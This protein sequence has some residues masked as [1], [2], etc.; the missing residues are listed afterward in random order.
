MLVRVL[1]TSSSALTLGSS[2]GT[3]DPGASLV[4]DLTVAQLE[5]V[6]TTLN[7]LKLKGFV[8]WQVTP[9]THGEEGQ[10]E[11]HPAQALATK[12]QG[13]LTLWVNA[14]TGADRNAGT[15]SQP[16]ASLVEAEKRIPDI[17][18]HPVTIHVGPHRGNGYQPPEFRQRVYHYSID[19][20]ADSGGTLGNGCNLLLSGV[21]QSGSSHVAVISEA[22]LGVDTYRG[23]TIEMLEGPSANWRRTIQYH[24]DENIVPA[25]LWEGGGIAQGQ[26]FRVIEPAVRL[27]M[28]QLVPQKTWRITAGESVY[29]AIYG[30]EGRYLEYPGVNLVNFVIAGGSFNINAGHHV[31]LFGCE[32][33]ADAPS[34]ALFQGPI[35]AGVD[36]IF[37][38]TTDNPTQPYVEYSNISR[39]LGGGRQDW[40][41]WGLNAQRKVFID[42]SSYMY[43]YGLVAPQLHIYGA[44]TNVHFRGGNIFEKGVTVR[45]GAIFEANAKVY[46]PD[47]TCH[48]THLTGDAITVRDFGSQVRLTAT[49]LRAENGSGVYLGEGAQALFHVEVGV[50]ADVGIELKHGAKAHLREVTPNFTTTTADIHI[51]PVPTAVPASSL[52]TVGDYVLEADGSA[53]YRV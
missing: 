46:L 16:L 42:H 4:R 31:R 18:A 44:G 47:L 22:G 43:F 3:L 11:F 41:G 17:V 28:A 20:V 1:N 27:D 19:V 48:I 2:L 36:Q 8:E 40:V 37:G 24:T 39:R 53:V 12:T 9:D 21:A 38:A 25:L 35:T 52:T 7:K 49:S 34:G 50:T 15:R 33:N 29:S 6:E 23:K 30:F 45:N 5:Q 26:A 32:L 10:T 51:G 14:H 13:P